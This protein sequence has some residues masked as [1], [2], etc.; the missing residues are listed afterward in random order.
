MGRFA[1]RL[2]MVCFLTHI[3]LT[4]QAKADIPKESQTETAILV[5]QRYWNAPLPCRPVVGYKPIGYSSNGTIVAAVTDVSQCYIQFDPAYIGSGGDL[6]GFCE[7]M[8][9]EVGHLYEYQ[10]VSSPNTDMEYFGPNWTP[11]L[12]ASCSAPPFTPPTMPPNV[13][14]RPPST[15]HRHKNRRHHHRYSWRMWSL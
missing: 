15:I 14:P 6:W 1:Y 2:I 12:V 4:A 7:L 13:K 5:A 3:V 11:P 10:D 8:I 9:H